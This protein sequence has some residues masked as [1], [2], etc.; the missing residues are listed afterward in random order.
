[1]VYSPHLVRVGRMAHVG[2][3]VSADGT[4]Y[5][6][7]SR[8]VCRTSRGLEVGEVLGE[9]T[10]GDS[11]ADGVLLRGVTI[12]DQL[13]LTRIERRQQEAFRACC[14]LLRAHGLPAVLMDVEHLFD[15]QS[16]FF[17]FLGD[18]DERVEALTGALA[19]AYEANVQFRRFTEA[20]IQGCGPGCGTDEAAGG[21]GGACGSCALSS[22]CGTHRHA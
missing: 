3:F 11:S 22:A 19:E 17:Y 21:C 10:R 9:V 18:V 16:L 7:R 13:L 1:V 15:G 2:R 8:V 12:Q 14:D 5:P 20:V 6:R 4:R